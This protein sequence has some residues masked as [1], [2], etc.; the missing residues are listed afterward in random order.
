MSAQR[1][2]GQS[3]RSFHAPNQVHSR[4]FNPL[5]H[6][7]AQTQPGD[8]FL[9]RIPATLNI[10]EVGGYLNLL[11]KVKQPGLRDRA[12]AIASALGIA[13]PKHHPRPRVPVAAFVAAPGPLVGQ[14]GCVRI[15]PATINNVRIKDRA[16]QK[17]ARVW[18]ADTGA[19]DQP[20]VVHELGEYPIIIRP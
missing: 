1:A 8:V 6:R 19:R 15:R 18:S 2:A 3:T 14:I 11:E 16:D 7:L 12:S 13:G 4:S 9:Y 5:S 10:T 20:A 17:S